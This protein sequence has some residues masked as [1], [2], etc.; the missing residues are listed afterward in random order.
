MLSCVSGVVAEPPFPWKHRRHGPPLHRRSARKMMMAL[1]PFMSYGP[2][3]MPCSCCST[4]GACD[5]GVRVPW[6]ASCWGPPV[7]LDVI[8]DESPERQMGLAA[9]GAGRCSAAAAGGHGPRSLLVSCVQHSLHQALVG[10]RGGVLWLPAKLPSRPS[11]LQERRP[12]ACPASC[13]AGA[14][15]VAWQAQRREHQQRQR[16]RGALQPGQPA[17]RFAVRGHLRLLAVGLQRLAPSHGS[18]HGAC[19]RH[20]ILAAH[21]RAVFEVSAQCHGLPG[22]IFAFVVVA[23]CCNVQRALVTH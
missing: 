1:S 19:G 4:C 17:V 20:T 12:R 11:T 16:R 14:P 13:G 10:G 8:R 7:T 21:R 6:S 2:F 9:G 18:L 15:R 5:C 22:A 3:C 23:Y